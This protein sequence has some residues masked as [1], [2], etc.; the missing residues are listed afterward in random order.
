VTDIKIFNDQQLIGVN[1][2]CVQFPR[3]LFYPDSAFHPVSV[4]RNNGSSTGNSI[5]PSSIFG[6]STYSRDYL[7]REIDLPQAHIGDLVILGHAGSYCATAHT[8][9]LGFPKAEEYFL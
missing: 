8:S 4:V 6:C 2:S 3:P 1:A 5:M 7:A 9:F